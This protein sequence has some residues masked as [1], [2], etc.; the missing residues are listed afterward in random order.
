M[1][2]ANAG[3]QMSPYSLLLIGS[4]AVIVGVFIVFLFMRSM[5]K[6]M[7]MAPKGQH[8]LPAAL[9]WFLLL[10]VFDLLVVWK[11]LDPQWSFVF[12]LVAYV[13]MFIMIA[14]AF[15]TTLARHFK[16]DASSTKK[17]QALRYL[18]LAFVLIQLAAHTSNHYG[19]AKF[20]YSIL[21][22]VGF[23]LWITYWFKVVGIR[24]CF[25]K[26]AEAEVKIEAEG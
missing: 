17:V 25:Q 21:G 4:L 8:A 1:D 24:K 18:G 3:S 7:R 22:L 26:E 16:D 23:V 12:G 11:V 14:Y 10:P 5:Q 9:L 19:A 20:G 6:T 2:F 15:P 13:F